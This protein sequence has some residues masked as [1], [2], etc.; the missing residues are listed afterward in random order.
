MHQYAVKEKKKYTPFFNFSD[1]TTFNQ[2]SMDNLINQ[3]I[4]RSQTRKSWKTLPKSSKWELVCA[5]F[6]KQEVKDVYDNDTINKMKQKMKQDIVLG[7]CVNVKY[8]NALAE[9][10]EIT[11]ITES[12]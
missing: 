7:K 11:E 3:E 8:D 10:T 9:I 6:E 5:Y 2:E 12:M 4:A 1:S